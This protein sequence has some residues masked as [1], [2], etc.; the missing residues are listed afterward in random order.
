MNREKEIE[1]NIIR[2]TKREKDR[3]IEEGR[4]RQRKRQKENI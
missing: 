1:K 3:K 2:D 4:G